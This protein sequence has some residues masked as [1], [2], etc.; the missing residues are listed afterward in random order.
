MSRAWFAPS[1]RSRVPGAGLTA[2]A[3]AARRTLMSS[4]LGTRMGMIVGAAVGATVGATV[5]GLSCA[6]APSPSSAPTTVWPTPQALRGCDAASAPLQ[7]RLWVSGFAEP[8]ALD[9]DEEAGTTAG[10]VR[11]P[12]GIVRRFTV[13]WFVE[14]GDRVVLLAQATDELDLTDPHAETATL[15]LADDDV[16]T[17]DCRDMG[18]GS[19][20]GGATIEVDGE[21]RPVCDLDDDGDSNLAEVCAGGDPLGGARP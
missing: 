19:L 10:V 1:R 13:D 21:P 18:D 2:A 17:A 12:P 7:A 4:L 20:R 3:A 16:V 15:T 11:V 9:V 8:F 6:P 5:G 14:D